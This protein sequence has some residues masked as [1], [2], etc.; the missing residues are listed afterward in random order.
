VTLTYAER[1]WTIAATQGSRS[2]AKPYVIRPAEALRMVA[3]IDVPGVHDAVE[4]IIAA[5][6]TE[7]EHRALRLREELAE[8][9]S[10]LAELDPRR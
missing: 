2:L 7:A 4:S 8:I 9:E 10:R 5:E 3:L 6:R 1:E